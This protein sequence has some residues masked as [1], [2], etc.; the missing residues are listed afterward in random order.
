VCCDRVVAGAPAAEEPGRVA[1]ACD[2]DH[3]APGRERRTV[4]GETRGGTERDDTF[5]QPE[6]CADEAQAVEEA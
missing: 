6:R 2:A 3:Q 1:R 4:D 5:V